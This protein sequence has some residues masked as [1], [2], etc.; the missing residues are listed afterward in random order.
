MVTRA[1]AFPSKFLK[2]ADLGG[3]AIAVVVDRVTQEEVGDDLKFV[4]YFKGAQKGLVLNGTNWD[5]LEDISGIADSDGWH[6]VKVVLVT[7][8]VR[9]N[10]QIYDGIR[11]KPQAQQHPVAATAAAQMGEGMGR[12]LPAPEAP[13]QNFAADLNDKIPF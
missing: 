6:G 8:R 9:Y 5:A 13:A 7:E 10:G 11:I 12:E 4:C 1:E 2:G 3:R